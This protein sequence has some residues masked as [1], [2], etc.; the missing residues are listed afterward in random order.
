[1]DT[2]ET[3]IVATENETT[4]VKPKTSGTKSK[5]TTKSKPAAKSTTTSKPQ[6]KTVKDSDS[7]DVR[8]CVV[9]RLTWKSAKTGYKVIWDEFGT[10]NPMTVEELRDMR[11][12]SRKFFEN[13][14]VVVEGDN[15]EDVLKYLQIDKYYKDFASIEDIDVIFEYDPDEA[16][17]VVKKF[18]YGLREVVARRAST[19]KSEGALD[20]VKMI[21]AIERATGFTIE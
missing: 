4:E 20:S 11:N 7:V 6:K 13:N 10:S 8:S 12:G 9:G 21:E 16:E 17:A 14:W 1:M 5:K 19:L 3:N 15:A 2:N 18:G